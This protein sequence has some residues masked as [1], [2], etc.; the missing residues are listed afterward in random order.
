M[1]Y[2]PRARSMAYCRDRRTATKGSTIAPQKE[3]QRPQAFDPDVDRH[4]SFVA[5]MRRILQEADVPD[6]PIE[7][8]EVA[9]LASGEATYR[10]W[11]PRADEPEGGYLGPA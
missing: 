6:V 7:R 4:P 3:T 8:L 11:L 2:I 10:Y 5:G 9:F 1:D